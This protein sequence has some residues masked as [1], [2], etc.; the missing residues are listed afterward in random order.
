MHFLKK[1]NAKDHTQIVTWQ[2]THITI[3]GD[4]ARLAHHPNW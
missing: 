1:N 2:V 3:F 4:V